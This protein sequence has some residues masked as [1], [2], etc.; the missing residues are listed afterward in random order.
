MGVE[1]QMDDPRVMLMYGVPFPDGEMARPIEDE[2]TEAAKSQEVVTEENA[3]DKKKQYKEF[4]DG[5]AAKPLT[6][7]DAARKL[8]EIRAEKQQN[9]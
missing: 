9:E 6:D 3:D 2:A 7:E 4:E 1:D 8:E 5:S